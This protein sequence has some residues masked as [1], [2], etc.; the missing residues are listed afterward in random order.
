[1]TLRNSL[2]TEQ[3]GLD[4]CCT[5]DLEPSPT[6]IPHNSTNSTQ[7]VQSNITHHVMVEQDILQDK[8]KLKKWASAQEHPDH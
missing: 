3:K 4:G 8:A 1:M 5:T 7:V 2:P 6:C